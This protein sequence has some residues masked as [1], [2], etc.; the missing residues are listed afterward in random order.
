MNPLTTEWS[1]DQILA[2]CARHLEEMDDL[3]LGFEP[4]SADEARHAAKLPR[5]G[6]DDVIEKVA[7]ECAIIDLTRADRDTTVAQ[8]LEAQRRARALREVLYRQHL[9]TMRLR[10]AR[11]RAESES[12]RSAMTFY[13]LLR[14]TA[15][16][17]PKVRAGIEPVLKFFQTRRAR[18]RGFE[19]KRSR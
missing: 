2:E 5:D 1:I 16:R 8:M 6:G 18:R 13:A 17:E 10:A 7:A 4:L 9:V 11:I 15:V 19:R 3:L 12:W 14:R